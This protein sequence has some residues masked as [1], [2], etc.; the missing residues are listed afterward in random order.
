M[1]ERGRYTPSQTRGL[2]AGDKRFDPRQSLNLAVPQFSYL[3]NE[4]ITSNM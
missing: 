4:I 2:R 3:Q 1:L